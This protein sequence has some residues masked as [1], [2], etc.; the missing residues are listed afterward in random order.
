MFCKEKFFNNLKMSNSI[1][2]VG[3]AFFVLHGCGSAK[4]HI[5]IGTGGITG[6]YYPVG[7]AICE[8]VNKKIPGSSIKASYESTGGSVFNVNAVLNRDMDFG[9]VQSDRQYQAYKGESEWKEKGAQTNLMSVFSLHSEAVTLV[10]SVQSGISSVSGLKGKRVNI[11][12]PGS[13][14]RQNAIDALLVG[15]LKLSDVQSEEVKAS[16]APIL[17]QD[18]RI[19]AFFYTVGH[20]SGAI[21]EATSGTVKVRLVPIIIGEDLLT[22]NPFYASTEILTSHYP[23]AEMETTNSVKTFGVKATLVTR[24]EM[25]D[26]L[27]YK[28]VKVV[29]ENL[30]TFKK[31]HP[32]L[33]DLTVKNML[34]GL[35]APLHPGAIKYYKEKNWK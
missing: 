11:G 26:E 30:E 24:A 22:E 23:Q 25:S 8:L 18:G 13:G 19:D 35:S 1:L 32:A 4:K 14:Q 20:P 3:L 6:V 5:T 29:M 15:D 21:K 31:I 9:I 12:N 27:V 34:E 17:L 7:G 10:A 33:A 28:L 2:I 16:E